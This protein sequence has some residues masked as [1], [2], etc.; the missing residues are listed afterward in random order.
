MPLIPTSPVP[1]NSPTSPIGRP[2]TDLGFPPPIVRMTVFDQSRQR[3]N[4]SP[5]R[6][7][8]SEETTDPHQ[9]QVFFEE[10]DR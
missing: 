5:V 4:L 7:V 10:P 3:G 9:E 1:P 2:S 6:L 8:F